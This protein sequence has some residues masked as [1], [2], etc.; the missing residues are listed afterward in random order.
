MYVMYVGP[1]VPASENPGEHGGKRQ[2]IGLAGLL[3]PIRGRRD[4]YSCF[5][6]E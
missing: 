5:R 1:A 4:S 6:T 2:K 3:H